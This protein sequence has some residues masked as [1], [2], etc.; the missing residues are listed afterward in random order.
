MVSRLEH[1]PGG[2]V[3]DARRARRAVVLAALS[4]AFVLGAVSLEVAAGAGANSPAD[5]LL[6]RLVPLAWPAPARVLWWL[7]V[8]GAALSFRLSL[9]RLG[10]RQRPWIIVVSVLPFVVFAAGIAAGADWST[11]H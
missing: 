3:E 7:A 2:V 5:P 6:A 11:W 9:R 4:A 10:V 1:Q 8:A